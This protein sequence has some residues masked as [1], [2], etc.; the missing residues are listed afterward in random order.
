MLQA[1]WSAKAFLAQGDPGKGASLLS[2]WMELVP[3]YHNHG[4][5]QCNISAAFHPE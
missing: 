4:S 1:G 5:P 2:L 3:A